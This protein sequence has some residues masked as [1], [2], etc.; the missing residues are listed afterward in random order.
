MN[1]TSKWYALYE[2]LVRGSI[3]VPFNIALGIA[4]KYIKHLYAQIVKWE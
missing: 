4:S 3:R 1:G 2:I